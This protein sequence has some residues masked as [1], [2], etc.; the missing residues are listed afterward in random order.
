[1][2]RKSLLLLPLA[3]AALAGWYLFDSSRSTKP[4]AATDAARVPGRAEADAPDV[5][6]RARPL[7]AAK[8]EPKVDESPPAAG[9]LT[10]PDGSRIR[11]LNGVKEPVA[12]L[13]P[14]E[15]PWSPITGTQTDPDGLQWYVHADGSRSTTQMV[16]RSDLGRETAI[17]VVANPKQA[18]PLKTA[19]EEEREATGKQPA[20][21]P[22]KK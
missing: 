18:L 1:M 16:W 6:L 19:E 3:L 10:L 2:A 5:K 21:G 7:A 8:A 9:L 15:L 13:W 22:A 14:P 11:A 12:L 17:S 4:A 20:R